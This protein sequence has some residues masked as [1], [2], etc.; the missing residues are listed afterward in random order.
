MLEREVEGWVSPGPVTDAGEGPIVCPIRVVLESTLYLKV[1]FERPCFLPYV[2]YPLFR[3]PT[4]TFL[5]LGSVE[6]Y[7]LADVNGHL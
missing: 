3:A 6:P 4:G 5:K 7:I 2:P 1:V